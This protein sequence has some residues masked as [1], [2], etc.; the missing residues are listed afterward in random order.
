MIRWLRQRLCRHIYV[1][2]PHWL[3]VTSGRKIA[4]VSL[5]VCTKCGHCS[6]SGIH[7]LA[8]RKGAP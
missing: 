7:P 3:L 1:S 2:T 4:K 5:L 6:L 8:E